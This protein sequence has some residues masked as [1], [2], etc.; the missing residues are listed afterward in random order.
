MGNKKQSTPRP[1]Q[2]FQ[3]MVSDASL[4]KLMPQVEDMVKHYV[5]NLGQQLAVQQSSTL[6]TLF[7]RVVVLESIV[8]EK[9][10]YSTEDLTSKVSELEDEKEGYS[11]VEKAELGDMVRVEIATKTKDQTDFQGS[12]RLKIYETG[13]GQTFGPELESSILGMSTGETKE[14]SFGQ[15]GQMTAKIKLDRASR[16]NKNGEE[17]ANN[18]QG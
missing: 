1:Q 13:S 12:S 6:E 7:A 5:Q 18:V 9:L 11:Q 4:N 8:M 16:K 14:V 10:G 17:D 15:D 2:S 3:Q